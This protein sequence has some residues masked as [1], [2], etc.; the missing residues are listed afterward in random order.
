MIISRLSVSLSSSP[1]VRLSIFPSIFG[2]SISMCACARVW[3]R[4]CACVRA[5]GCV[6]AHVR[7]CVQQ[8]TSLGINEFHPIS[9]TILNLILLKTVTTTST[10]LNCSLVSSIYKS[11]ICVRLYNVIVAWTIFHESRQTCSSLGSKVFPFCTH[12]NVS[13]F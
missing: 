2:S 4:A 8:N 12:L 6:R 3:E 5:C 9:N 7:A 11:C 13:Y 1:P 10:L